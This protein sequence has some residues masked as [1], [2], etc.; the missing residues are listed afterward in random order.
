MGL[1]L[2]RRRFLECDRCRPALQLHARSFTSPFEHVLIEKVS[3]TLSCST[4]PRQKD[5]KRQVWIFTYGETDPR[6]R[7]VL[8]F[9]LMS[10]SRTQRPG[11][12][13]W[14]R[15][16]RFK[17]SVFTR[18]TLNH[19]VLKLT[20]GTANMA[21]ASGQNHR[22]H[23]EWLLPL[24]G[25]HSIMMEKLAQPGE[26]GGGGCT[27]TPFHSIYHHVQ[28]CGV[29]FQLRGQIQ[30]YTEYFLLCPCMYSVVETRVYA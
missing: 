12:R 6:R 30:R 18:R 21:A 28:S 1:G 23:T 26:G 19:I 9:N 13:I 8:L 25:L 7:W 4:F 17:K 22:V 27:P 29:H 15:M 3:K 10:Y 24:S 14:N 20:D 11:L 5:W 16:A 2:R